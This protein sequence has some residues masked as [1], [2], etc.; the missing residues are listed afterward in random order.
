MVG[1][2]GL[3]ADEAYLFSNEETFCSLVSHKHEHERNSEV[4][5]AFRIDCNGR[6]PSTV[7]ADVH[8]E[9]FLD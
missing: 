4:Q 1:A 9:L 5:K 7:L 6:Q 2:L 3:H 8:P